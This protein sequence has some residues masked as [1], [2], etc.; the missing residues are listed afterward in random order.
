MAN[1]VLVSGAS[2]YLGTHIVNQLLSSGYSVRALAR[3]STATGLRAV[4]AD[5]GDRFEVFEIEDVSHSTFSEAFSDVGAVIHAASPLPSN[6]TAEQ[7]FE[8]A[9]DGT[10]NV[11]TQAEKAGVNKLVVTGSFA[12]VR[13]PQ[14]SYTANDWNPVTKEQAFS[15]ALPLMAIYAASKKFA[16]LALWEWADRNPHVDVTVLNPTVLYGPLSPQ[17]QS[18]LPSK[19]DFTALSTTTFIYQLIFPDG[20]LIPNQLQ[21]SVVDIAKIHVLALTGKPTS[22]VG[23]KRLVFANPEVI[24]WKEAVAVLEKERPQLKDRLIKTDFP[25]LHPLPNLEYERLEDVLGFKKSD[26]TPFRETLLATIDSLLVVE[27]KWKE[28]GYEAVRPTS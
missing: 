16:E 27:K 26:F 8:I 18:L 4:Y 15:G 6:Q 3:G 13:N 14:N 7:L 12:S 22:E 24:D 21:T 20:Q 23:R 28:N 2:G 10:L 1:R 11:A 9:V 19:P 17:R 5:A 25:P